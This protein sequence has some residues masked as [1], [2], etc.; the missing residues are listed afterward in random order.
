MFEDENKFLGANEVFKDIL[1]IFNQTLKKLNN[2][3]Q[4][5]S[6][7]TIILKDLSGEEFTSNLFGKKYVLQKSSFKFQNNWYKLGKNSK[8]GWYELYLK[9][10]TIDANGNISS[11]FRFVSTFPNLKSAKAAAERKVN[12]F[13]NIDLTRDVFQRVCRK[14]VMINSF[15]VNPIKNSYSKNYLH[16]KLLL[17]NRMLKS[18]SLEQFYLLFIESLLAIP[19]LKKIISINVPNKL[20]KFTKISYFGVNCCSLCCFRFLPFRFFITFEVC[21][22]KKFKQKP[23]VVS[24]NKEAT[25]SCGIRFY[26]Y[27]KA[28]EVR[29]GTANVIERVNRR[30]KK[31]LRKGLVKQK[32]ISSKQFDEVFALKR[33]SVEDLKASSGI[34]NLSFPTSGKELEVKEYLVTVLQ[35]KFRI[36]YLKKC[37]HK[38]FILSCFTITI[39]RIFKGYKIRKWYKDWRCKMLLAANGI[40]M[41]YYIS[42]LERFKNRRSL[43]VIPL[44]KFA[45]LSLLKIRLYFMKHHIRKVIK[46]QSMFRRINATKF[47]QKLK[48][49]KYYKVIYIPSLIK[50]QR[51]IRVVLLKLLLSRLKMSFLYFN[52]F[53]PCIEILQTRFREKLLYKRISRRLCPIIVSLLYRFYLVQ[54]IRHVQEKAERKL[55]VRWKKCNFI[56]EIL[57]KK[58]KLL[59]IQRLAAI[60]SMRENFINITK[61]TS[62]FKFYK[63]TVHF[64]RVQ[65]FLRR[66]V[67]KY[68]VKPLLEL[69]QNYRRNKYAT[70][71]QSLWRARKAK[72]VLVQSQEKFNLERI[73]AT[74]QVQKFY[75]SIMLKE[76]A[77]QKVFLTK[78]ELSQSAIQ[79]LKIHIQE[80]KYEQSCLKKIFNQTKH[81]LKQRKKDRLESL[82][83]EKRFLKQLEKAQ[84]LV[85]QQENNFSNNNLSWSEFHKQETRFLTE[86]IEIAKEESFSL[87]QELET[88]Q[89]RR[90]YLILEA[91]QL[92]I[93]SLTLKNALKQK[94][95]QGSGLTAALQTYKEKRT[96]QREIYNYKS[97][98][99]LSRHI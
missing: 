57:H 1:L 43:A 54:S 17:S 94:T 20:L 6:L 44:L 71:I 15:N 40:Q 38:R 49:D 75:R 33:L 87:Q 90:V 19:K 30:A 41:L 51:T 25:K 47:V 85:E 81:T 3:V 63:Q 58:Y 42:K 45:R 53:I 97:R 88:F 26:G 21:K 29:E 61:R 79:E 82:K 70:A 68:R 98:L 13:K 7:V 80:N 22:R 92:Q 35:T 31:N 50:I 2:N 73:L 55:V 99:S 52:L 24:K 18:L 34:G 84:T 93:E 23:L 60:S 66:V 91:E 37:L 36:R 9:T 10:F 8:S 28:I 65:C 27:D 86:A 76:K 11:K 96:R 59:T 46:L 67:A 72:L 39:K 83:Y 56:F 77:F 4:N 16:F 12:G 74:I 69:L 89:L 14:F 5:S 48:K 32:L 62:L 95:S 64:A 78:L